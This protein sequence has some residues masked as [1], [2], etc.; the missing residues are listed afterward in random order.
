MSRIGKK[1][2]K[3]GDIV[4]IT[5]PMPDE[6]ADQLYVVVQDSMHG[7]YG[8]D[9]Q[10]DC[11]P[12]GTGMSIPGISRIEKK[13][14]AVVVPAEKVEDAHAWIEKQNELKELYTQLNQLQ[15]AYTELINLPENAGK[16]KQNVDRAKWREIN[17]LS[18]KVQELEAEN[19]IE[20]EKMASGGRFKHPGAD[21]DFNAMVKKVYE[22]V[23]AFDL[24]K[25]ELQKE[26]SKENPDPI[27]LEQLKAEK[28]KL[29][30]YDN[31]FDREMAS[32]HKAEYERGGI[33]KPEEIRPYWN[34]EAKDRLLGKTVRFARMMTA[35]EG[36]ALGW[37]NYDNCL[38][39]QFGDGSIIYPSQDDEGNDAGFF[40]FSGDLR[41]IKDER[42][43]GQY[44]PPS[45]VG[46]KVVN[47]YY[48]LPE[49]INDHGWSSTP[50]II[51]FENKFGG[52]IV[53]TA[54]TD[55]EGNDGGAIFGQNR[56]GDFILPVI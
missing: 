13:D 8:D 22:K 40:S 11:E 2:E 41:E 50:V 3:K 30:K 48:A 15:T 47:A 36:A 45:L 29:A 55:P 19:Q 56:K 31:P 21:E 5:N 27:R 37:S 43:V 46:A 32:K 16:Q 44:P 9:D 42:P 25:S 7:V 20:D 6:D 17:R 18:A 12:L 28:M 35:A 4:K 33:L 53:L 49:L 24:A 14:L 38:V 10:I 51:L 34:K 23:K 1:P 54:Q 52:T 39:I 26:R